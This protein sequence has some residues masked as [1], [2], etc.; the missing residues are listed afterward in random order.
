VVLQTPLCFDSLLLPTLL[1]TIAESEITAYDVTARMCLK[2]K[3]ALGVAF[4]WG[5][6]IQNT[7]NVD[8]YCYYYP[9]GRRQPII[10]CKKHNVGW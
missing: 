8:N 9:S 3:E 5:L 2:E 10:W 7:R 6:A 4:F 1:N